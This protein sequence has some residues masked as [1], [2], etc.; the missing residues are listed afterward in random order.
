MKY[1]KILPCSNNLH[2]PALVVLEMQN[3]KLPGLI[4]FERK[5]IQSLVDILS[6]F[7]FGDP[8]KEC[9]ALMLALILSMYD[10]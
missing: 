10:Y 6:L 1:D 4:P 2:L 3:W 8:R 5:K 7:C 9:I